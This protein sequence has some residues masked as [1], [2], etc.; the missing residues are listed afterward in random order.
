LVRAM[1]PWP[2]ACTSWRGG[3]LRVWRARGGEGQAPAGTVPAGEGRDIPGQVLAV[4]EEGITAAARDGT[5]VL[6]EV[7]PEGGRRMPAGEFLRGHRIRPGERFGKV[8]T[9][10][11]AGPDAEMIE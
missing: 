7:Q 9:G 1:N 2:C 11:P 4:G 8:S 6:L 5:V 3:I 10:A